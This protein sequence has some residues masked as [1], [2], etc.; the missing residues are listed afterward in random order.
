MNVVESNLHPQLMGNVEKQAWQMSRNEGRVKGE[1]NSLGDAG[2]CASTGE[3]MLLIDVSKEDF[4]TSL[5]SF[6][7]FSQG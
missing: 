6:V 2:V 4:L 3:L 7:A 5:Y 1:A